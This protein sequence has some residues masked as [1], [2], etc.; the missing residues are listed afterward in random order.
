MK[1]NLKAWVMATAFAVVSIAVFFRVYYHNS[2]RHLPAL[3]R[4]E[5]EIRSTTDIPSHGTFHVTKIHDGDTCDVVGA[6]G[7]PF[8]IRLAGIDA[9]ELAQEYGHEARDVLIALIGPRT[10]S[11]S[12][13]G[14]DK[15]GR[16]LAQVYC[17]ETWINK[18]MLLRGAAWA[19]LAGKHFDDFK[20][21]EALAK[22]KRLGLWSSDN[23]KPPW[24]ARK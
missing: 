7:V 17:G 10:V 1:T 9:P 21:A 18:E 24:E 13:L 3:P 4:A 6:D 8:T 14:K 16:H 5:N 12:E 15:Y 2:N 19:Y 11:L 23:P 20:N 22:S